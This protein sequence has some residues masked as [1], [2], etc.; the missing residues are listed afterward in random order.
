[1]KAAVIQMRSGPDKRANIQKALDLF[2]R[3]AKHKAN[4]VCLPELFHYRGKTDKKFIEKNIAENI[5]GESVAPFMEAAARTKTCILAGSVYEKDR[6]GKIFDT[7]V[8]IDRKGRIAAKY[9]KIHLFDARV[10]DDVYRETKVF[11]PGQ[12]S[13]SVW[14]GTFKIGLSVCFDLRFPELYRGYL[15]NGCHVLAVPSGFTQ[16][17][18]SAHWEVLL[19]ARA[20]ENQC[21][22]LASNQWGKDENNRE[23]YG[24]SMIVGP[25]GEIL[26]RAPESQDHILYAELTM[27]E[28][29]K[30]RKK[31]P[32]FCTKG[33]ICQRP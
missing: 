7:A 8:F 26:A 29:Q 2:R 19:R 3:A 11:T 27:D 9:R 25:W 4:V 18:G 15:Q 1:M 12:K 13:V 33:V 6:N 5:P 17:T 20:I 24:N 10:G 21:Y 22:V 23:T 28:L 16:K 31:I 14:A 32:L 30:V